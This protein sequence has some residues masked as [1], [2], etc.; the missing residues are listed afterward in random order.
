MKNKNNPKS[1]KLARQKRAMERWLFA[2][3]HP[4]AWNAYSS[5]GT[6]AYNGLQVAALERKVVDIAN[7]QSRV[8]ILEK[9]G[10]N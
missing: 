4:S 8:A 10:V 5:F 9:L 2:I 6:P 3:E 1:K 7:I